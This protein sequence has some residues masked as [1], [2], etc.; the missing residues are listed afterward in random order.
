VPNV[1]RDSGSLLVE[2]Y[3]QSEQAQFYVCHTRSQ[4][5]HG[6]IHIR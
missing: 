6:L 1:T 3:S 5:G 2:L 4:Y